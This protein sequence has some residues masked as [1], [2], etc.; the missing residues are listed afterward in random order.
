MYVFQPDAQG[1]S[2]CTD[3]CAAAWPALEG[4]ATAGEGADSSLLGTAARPDNGA[5]Q[6]TYD[7]WPL[8]YFAQDA[9]PGDVRG[10]GVNGI[11]F[12]VGPDGAP[13][14]M[15]GGASS[16]TAAASSGGGDYGY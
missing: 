11:W 4:P 14:G 3:Q 9:A 15:D 6:V 5:E 13:I 1:P 16:T 7:G 12:V 8:Y 2:T 10:Q